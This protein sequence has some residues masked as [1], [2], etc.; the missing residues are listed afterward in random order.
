MKFRKD[1]NGLRA[2]AVIGV[3]LYHF[4]ISFVPGGFS[5][6]DVFFVISGFLMTGIIFQAIE[7]NSFSILNFYIARA[8]RIIPAL[9]FLCII[10]LFFCWFYL[11]PIDYKALGKDVAS[12]IVFF[13]NMTYLNEAGYFNASS[14]E[15]WLLHTWSLSVE[16]QFYILYPLLLVL[17]NKIIPIKKMNILIPLGT[18]ISL[19]FCIIATYLWPEAAYYLLP[20][21]AWEMMFGGIAYLYPLK[22]DIKYKKLFEIIGIALILGSYLIISKEN[23]WPGYL[24]LIPVIGTFLIIQANINN[25]YFTDNIIFQKIG[26]W[27]YSIYLWHWPLAVVIYYYSLPHQFS[28][29]LIILS[30]L[31]G[32]LSYTYIEKVKFRS[33]FYSLKSFVKYKQIH[34][35]FVLIIIGSITNLT[36]GLEFHYPEEV[37]IAS[38]ETTNSNPYKC[39]GDKNS[40]KFAPCYIG[41]KKNIKAIIIGD[42]HADSL[43]TSLS[44]LF[45][46]ENEGIL[47]LVK[48]ACPF[49]LNVKSIKY[50]NSCAIENEK[51]LKY[52]EEKYQGIPIFWVA[53]TAAY[54]YGQ[55]DPARISK[56]SD[57]KPIFY[58][59]KKHDKADKDLFDEWNVNLK[60]SICS[61]AKNNKV[62]MLHPTP[63]MYINVPKILARNLIV[64]NKSYDYSIDESLYL[65]RNLLVR[66]LIEDIAYKCKVNTLDPVHLLCIKGR[67]NSLFNDRSIYRDGDHLSEYGNKLLTPMFKSVL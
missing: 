3:V 4:N 13:S 48:S 12:S 7:N 27:S 42:S 54:F 2:I 60:E 45:N 41:N 22:L 26:N 65:K 47:A 6:V 55:T 64:K 24:A 57:L 9:A 49:I 5:G 34:I 40:N 18:L 20:T 67:C 28:Y 56:P 8:N 39:L 62:F 32:Y 61:L 23:S 36:N 37:L 43:V 15:K 10:L 58:F 19:I 63:E 1:I 52:I 38:N 31:L 33:D 14:N 51:R 59:S 11:A 35:I 53:R 21:R 44:S 46:L 25:S 29:V 17:I 66:E 30:V 50:G 16:W